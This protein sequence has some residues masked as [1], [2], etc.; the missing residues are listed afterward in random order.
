ML[1]LRHVDSHERPRLFNLPEPRG[2]VFTSEVIR[3]PLGEFRFPY[4]RTSKEE[5]DE[6]T[7]R[8]DPAILA[9]ANGRRDRPNRTSLSNNLIS[10]DFLDLN[11]EVNKIRK[12]SWL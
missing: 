11:C 6:G 7:V 2:L 3:D 1:K 8:I 5:H 4:P 9:Q 10:N 12:Y